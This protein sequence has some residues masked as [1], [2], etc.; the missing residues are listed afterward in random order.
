[1]KQNFNPK[2]LLLIVVLLLTAVVVVACS[3][4]EMVPYGD[5]NLDETYVE[6]DGYKVTVKELYDQ[7]R[8]QGA[9]TLSGLIDRVLFESELAVVRAALQNNDEDVAK[10]L[11]EMVNSAIFG[12]S[13]QESLK[14]LTPTNIEMKIAAYVDSLYLLDNGLDR[15]LCTLLTDIKDID[16]PFSNTKTFLFLLNNM[17]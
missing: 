15:Q 12:T 5:L 1:M 8:M 7:L 16:N 10:Q 3:K 6:V 2:R 9:Q 11:D 17:N 13:D 4:K 14:D